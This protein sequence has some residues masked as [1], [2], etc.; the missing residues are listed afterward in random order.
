MLHKSHVYIFS[1]SFCWLDLQQLTRVGERFSSNPKKQQT[2]EDLFNCLEGQGCSNEA[3]SILWLLLSRM[4]GQNFD[5]R[6]RVMLL[7]WGPPYVK[8]YDHPT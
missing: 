7:K 8:F 5:K 3:P 6:V 1:V 4:N 2:N